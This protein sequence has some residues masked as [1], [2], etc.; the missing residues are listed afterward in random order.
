MANEEG[1]SGLSTRITPDGST[2]RGG[3]LGRGTS[4]GGD[5]PAYELRDLVD[6]RVTREA[7]RLAVATPA[8]MA[9]DGRDVELVD[10][11]AQAH[12][13]SRAV[14]VGARRLA[15][16]HSHLGALDRAEVVD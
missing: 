13:P 10:A 1:P 16:Q 11:R 8:G 3:T 5:R 12:P 4:R 9:R 15:D 14:A 2:P 7:G 6:R